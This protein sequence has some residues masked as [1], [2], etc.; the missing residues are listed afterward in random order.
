MKSNVQKNGS[1]L[2]KS[3]GSIVDSP[4]SPGTPSTPKGFEATP[5]GRGKR[6]NLQKAQA[7]CGPALSQEL[8]AA[9]NAEAD[10]GPHIPPLAPIGARIA[11]SAK[12]TVERNRAEA[13]R[14]YVRE[15]EVAAW[16]PALA[17]L[18]ALAPA[19]AYAVSR[20]PS[21][22]LRYPQLAL[23]YKMRSQV[24]AKAQQTRKAK[25]ASSPAKP[26]GT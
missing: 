5:P 26:Q 9:K 3:S 7:A 21:I 11:V 17:D 13:W 23:F 18:D 24:A 15:E 16:S 8:S 12:W 10:F 4:P 14:D 22:A 1:H 25:K 20:D 2:S 6:I 19:F